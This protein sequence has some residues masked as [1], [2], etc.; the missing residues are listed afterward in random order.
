MSGFNR[1]KG[2]TTQRCF[3]LIKLSIPLCVYLINTYQHNIS[4]GVFSLVCNMLTNIHFPLYS[5]DMS[6]PQQRVAKEQSPCACLIHMETPGLELNPL[7]V[8]FF[9]FSF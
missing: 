2:P 6:L 4:L 9:P 7:P 5:H 8:F 1:E 3:S